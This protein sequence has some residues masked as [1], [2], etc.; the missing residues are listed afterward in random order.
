M[1]AAADPESIDRFGWLESWLARG[2]QPRGDGYAALAARGIRVDVDL[3]RH[4]RSDDLERYAPRLVIVR[5]PVDDHHAP[6]EAQA[7]RWLELLSIA[8]PHAPVYV[9]CH[10]GQGRTAT[11]CAPARVAQGWNTDAAIDEQRRFGF[12]P[13]SESRQAAFL[14]EF[15]ASLRSGHVTAPALPGGR[16][17]GSALRAA[18]QASDAAA[19]AARRWM[20]P[21]S[22]GSCSLRTVT[23]PCSPASAM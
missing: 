21:R 18:F 4:S 8:A 1:R 14:H 3:R 5:I 6:D 16:S 2:A 19:T 11:F 9:H 20:M 7:L 13:D 12:D 23:S 22:P 17:R 10:H 15:E